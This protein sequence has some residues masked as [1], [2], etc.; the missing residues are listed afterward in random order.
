MSNSFSVTQTGIV[1]HQQNGNISVDIPNFK[2]LNINTDDKS[3]TSSYHSYDRSH[4][5]GSRN[6]SSNKYIS[7]QNIIWANLQEE[8]FPT[9]SLSNP[10]SPVEIGSKSSVPVLGSVVHHIDHN[11][12]IIVNITRD[13]HLLNPGIVVRYLHQE[14]DNYIIRT[15]GIGNG[16]IGILNQPGSFLNVLL[17]DQTWKANVDR[18]SR[19]SIFEDNQPRQ[20]A[21]NSKKTSVIPE[22]NVLPEKFGGSHTPP[23]LPITVKVP[24]SGGGTHTSQN[25]PSS[26]MHFSADHYKPFSP[27]PKP[28]ESSG[29]QYTVKVDISGFIIGLT[30]AILDALFRPQDSNRGYTREGTD[31]NDVLCGGDHPDL[32]AGKGG[33]DTLYGGGDNDTLYG[34]DG[35]DRLLGG[36]GNDVL[37]GDNG[38]D[39][40]SGESGDDVLYGGPG[41]DNLDGCEGNDRVEGGDGDDTVGGAAGNDAIYGNNGHDT[42]YG[43]EGNDLLGGGEGN[44][45]LYAWTGNDILYGDEGDDLLGGQPGDDI[46]YGGPGNDRLYGDE[47]NDTLYAGEGNDLMD[48]GSG[49]DTLYGENGDDTLY[50]QEG[51]D[52]LVGGEGND[53]LYAW[54]GNDTLY[55]ENGN[56]TLLGQPGDDRLSGGEGNDRLEGNEGHDTLFGGGGDDSLRGGEGNDM[57]TGGMGNDQLFGDEGDDTLYGDDGDD[58]LDG[59]T[60]K[61]ILIGGPGNDT[62]KGSTHRKLFYGNEGQDTLH[63]AHSGHFSGGPGADIFKVYK[64]IPLSSPP[65]LTDFE[66]H[67]AGETIDL[68]DFSDITSWGHLRLTQTT[69]DMDS[70]AQEGLTMFARNPNHPSGS[71]MIPVVRISTQGPQSHD[72]VDLYNMDS[73]T[74][75]ASHFTFHQPPQANDWPL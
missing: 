37:H 4:I 42:L 46:L 73:H 51:D 32:L 27:P 41:N 50:G 74:L 56:D 12:K 45:T 40:M 67:T 5:V 63:I 10:N 39:T 58:I 72:L 26:V 60:G 15:I 3:W 1:I 18:I 75:N 30:A 43:G 29:W 35:N 9:L 21:P 8:P 23:P 6:K 24:G 19:E 54:T 53:A 17:S 61:D 48:G 36:A 7:D 20:I 31:G 70:D 38:D 55:G 44:D 16:P 14:G 66:P 2:S 22:P 71:M 13:D 57:L 28:H 11:N 65:I 25:P 52:V 33:N 69:R 47:G 62:L 34:H 49:N 59:G 68:S 64:G